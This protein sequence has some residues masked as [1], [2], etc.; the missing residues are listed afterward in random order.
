MLKRKVLALALGLLGFGVAE[1]FVVQNIQF[2]GLTRIP[3]SSVMPDVPVK[4][5]DDL[6]PA[7][8]N[9][10]INDLF[11]TGYFKNIQLSQQGN[12]L[13]ISVEELPT[14][15]SIDIKG[16]SL[17]KTEDLQTALSGM[18][19]QVGNMFNQNLIN[20]IKQSLVAQYNS[21]GKYAV[22]VDVDIAPKSNN[23][24]G[25]TINISEG[26]NADIQSINITGNKVFSNRKLAHQLPISTWGLFTFI[27]KSNVYS[28]DKLSAALQALSNFYQNNGYINIRVNSAEASIDSTHTKAFITI[29]ITEGMQY[30]FSG[31][32][33]K[34]NLIL[35]K[36]QLMK[37]VNIKANA[38]YSKAQ[39]VA[40]QQA[41]INAL[42]DQGYA[43]VNVNPVPVT[44]D[45]NHTVFEEFYVTPGQKV[46]VHQINFNSNTVTEDKTLRERMKFVEG[47]TYSQTA[48]NESVSNLQQ[49]SFLQ[50][51][52]V[53]K[54]P[55][56][57]ASNQI[58]VGYNMT[59][60]S[61]NSVT[62]ALGYSELDGPLVQFGFNMPNL[63]GTGNIFNI[64]TQISKPYQSVNLTFTQPYFT[65][66]GISQSVGFYFQRVDASEEGLADFSTNSYG[67]T[68]T[69]GIPI[70]TWNTFSVGGGIDRTQL[71]QPGD[72][73]SQTVTNFVDQYGSEYNTYTGTVGLSRNSTND[74]WFPTQGSLGNLSSTVAAPFS[75]LTWYKLN[76]SGTWYHAL[77][78]I[79]TFS[80]S[81][82]AGYG[83]GYGRTDNLPFFQN[84][85]SGG[86]GSVRGYQQS[87]M[88]P[89][90][91][92]VCT[93]PA[94]CALGSTSEGAALGGNLMVYSSVQLTYPVPFV[95]NPNMKFISFVDAGNVYNTYHS[96]S[97]WNAP[98]LPTSPNFTNIGYT[99]GVGLEWV[100]PEL[101]PVGISF[102]VPLNKLAGDDTNIFQFTLGTFF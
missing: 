42:G 33:L 19:L 26:L 58:N 102:A 30:K 36:A 2:E 25:L 32:D 94:Q 64:N 20:E 49:L 78:H 52:N 101:G 7:L 59:E 34:G 15:A 53:T 3:Q 75:D 41:I 57:G 35:P 99:A 50:N 92:I 91:I 87:Q 12:T 27:T 29:N 60:K 28:P 69:Y 56:P 22:K 96:S 5:G 45:T 54:T 66:S 23:R 80:A 61:A 63:F 11:A 38:V 9:E 90:D 70:S 48:V 39:V 4:L 62:G 24:V 83:N 73:Q 77:N 46:Y 16:N 86:W 74:P 1:A 85:Y 31:F 65:L 40:A 100:I 44:N 97:V 14:I 21:Q 81:A 55:V 82:G 17:I 6:T 37:L 10:V 79:F 72:S 67:A 76:A 71:Q 89:Q 43:F 13:I 88:G 51:V 8:S 68:L 98:A 84:Y 18:G 95:D 93:D 47:S